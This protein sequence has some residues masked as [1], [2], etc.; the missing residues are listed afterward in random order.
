MFIDLLISLF[1]LLCFLF[2]QEKLEIW[3][4]MWKISHYD[5]MNDYI[6]LRVNRLHKN[7]GY[8]ILIKG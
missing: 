1:N 4:F 5:H 2:L 3:N 7:M 8:I 6:M